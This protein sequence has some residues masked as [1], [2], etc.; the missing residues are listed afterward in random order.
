MNKKKGWIW[1]FRGFQSKLDG[2][3]V[4]V[5][6]DNLPEEAKDEIVDLLNFLQKITD[7]LW[8]K[9]EFDR[10]DGAGGISE[11]RPSDTRIEMEGELINATF[12]IYG[13]FAPNEREYTFLHGVRKVVRN[14]RQGKR[15]AADR[16]RQID[17]GEA[18]TH[19]FKF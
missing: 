6:F 8:R 16:L 7:R 4:Q 11:L 9:P 19:Q 1:A 18:T 17:R 5:W 10:L 14:D 15:V 2:E 3:P 13:Y 12:R